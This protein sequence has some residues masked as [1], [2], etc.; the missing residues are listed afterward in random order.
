MTKTFLDSRL[1]P[2]AVL[3]LAAYAK[4]TPH[5][6]AGTWM[7]IAALLL[8]TVIL[9]LAR[10]DRERVLAEPFTIKTGVFVPPWMA[11]SSPAMG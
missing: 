6:P 7:L 1:L 8:A 2:I 3:A 5:A 11:G 9:V 4:L 10:A